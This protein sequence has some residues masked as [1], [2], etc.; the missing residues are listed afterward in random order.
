MVDAAY[1][2]LGVAVFGLLVALVWRYGARLMRFPCPAW[3]AWTV[4]R[5]NPFTSATRA[6]AVIRSA[7]IQPG[8]QALDLGCGPGRITVPLAQ[9]VLPGGEVL[10][11]D[12]QA[13]M[14]RRAQAKAD[15]AGL[16]NIQFLRAAIGEGRLP[17]GQFDCAFLVTVLGEVPDR[18]GALAEVYAAL[19]PGGIL[20]VAE[21]ALDPHYQR[22][23]TVLALAEPAGFRQSTFAGAWY[24][25]SLNLQKPPLR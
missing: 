9:A 14:L 5:D 10:A 8:M 4:E 11:V 6:A 24:G 21:I 1:I 25:Y 23:G 12:V 3:L 19:K 13:A 18:Q 22:R 20:T 7:G 15:A 16:T 17:L 2:I